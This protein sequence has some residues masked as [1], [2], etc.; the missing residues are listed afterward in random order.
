VVA[1]RL[2]SDDV[3]KCLTGLFVG[4]GPPEHILSDNGPEFAAKAVRQLARQARRKAT[5]KQD[6][7]EALGRFLFLGHQLDH[8]VGHRF[9]QRQGLSGH[10]QRGARERLATVRHNAASRATTMSVRQRFRGS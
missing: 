6:R 1:R 9:L 7:S 5:R 8:I 3:L 10:Q 4:H 2:R